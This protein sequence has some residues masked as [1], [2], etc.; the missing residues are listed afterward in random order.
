M[1]YLLS[2]C[3]LVLGF[4][5]LV[6]AVSKLRDPDRFKETIIRF[7]IV[8]RARAV[9]AAVLV[10]GWEVVIAA[11]LLVG[12]AYLVVG[13]ALAT[14]L[15][16]TLS[17][18]LLSVIKRNISAS[19]NCFGPGSEQVSY[20]S[21]GRNGFLGLLALVGFY[22]SLFQ[23]SAASLSVL[24]TTLPVALVITILVTQYSAILELFSS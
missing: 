17:L 15:L 10:I 1:A 13:F 20:R 22:L 18:V 12:G 14:L 21:L 24:I 23:G 6:S 3:K 2:F 19:C 4:L 16:L 8:T 9:S 5:F 11:F 7:Q